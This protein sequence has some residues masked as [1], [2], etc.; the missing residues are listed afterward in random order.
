LF[1]NLVNEMADNLFRASWKNVDSAELRILL[2]A[3][4]G[5]PGQYQ[6]RI[7]NPDKFHLPLAGPS[8]QI[9]LT[10]KDRN[11]VALH[12][13]AAFDPEVW[14]RISEEIEGLIRPGPVKIG[15]D[16]SFSGSR[17]LGSWRGTKSGVQILPPPHDAPLAPVENAQHPFILEFP[18]KASSLWPLMNYRR[19]REHHKLTLLLNVLL[20]VSASLQPRRPRH[21]WA[22]V[23]RGDGKGP[24]I[25]WVQ[26]FYFVNFGQAVVDELSRQTA[27]QLEE[28]RPEEYD[29]YDGYDG[30][31]L[32]IPADLD[33]SIYR[34]TQLSP[35]NRSKLDLATFWMDVASRQWTT[36]VSSSF[37]SLVTGI[38][39]LT[40]EGT[41]HHV[42]CDKCKREWPHD[43]PGAG[44]RFRDFFE[45]Y[46]PGAAL[47]ERRNEIYRLRSGVLHGSKLMQL[48]EDRDFG[49]DPPGWNERELHRE[50]WSVTKAALRKWLWSPPVS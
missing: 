47:S 10:F 50:L 17:V 34:Y 31:G 9:T 36:S 38:E 6:D 48:D 35:K 44:Q 41:A 19:M 21:F 3:R 22:G 20:P 12:P 49:W 42:Y 29:A 27:E 28:L 46:A 45:K 23:L 4:I 37:A 32:R 30:K 2:D 40:E 7:K 18:I 15:R 33:E 16:C 25:T 43:V 13:G 8:C 26:E 24:E 39:S 11:I 14:K 5:G 1:R